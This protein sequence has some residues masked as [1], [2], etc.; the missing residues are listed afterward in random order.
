MSEIMARDAAAGGGG[1][2]ADKAGE[3]MPA[4]R[5]SIPSE[6][7]DGALLK[8]QQEID[9]VPH[10]SKEP[11]PPPGKT[12]P[13]SNRNRGLSFLLLPPVPGVAGTARG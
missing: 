8:D 10:Q 5:G 2:D 3:G 11:L 6:R 1:P 7:P 13:K 9:R 4:G 12:D